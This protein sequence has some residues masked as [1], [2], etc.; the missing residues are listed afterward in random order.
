MINTEILQ[1]LQ[2][3]DI[4]ISDVPSFLKK[5]NELSNG[6]TVLFRGHCN[7]QYELIPSIGRQDNETKDFFYNK[8]DEK[9]MFLEFK[10][11]YSLFTDDKPSSDIDVLFLAQHF[12]VPTR[13]LDWTYNPLVALFFAC[14]GKEEDGGHVYTI[15]IPKDQSIIKDGYDFDKGFFDENKY[16]KEQYLIVPDY[17][18]RR[19]LNQKGLF[20]L[21]K[22]PFAKMD[23][24][25]TFIISNKNGV[26][27][28]LSNMG[29]TESMVFPTLDGLGKEIANKYKRL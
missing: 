19:F 13:L 15:T 29:I 5:L 24:S 10:R 7:K 28:E 2:A 1:S 16:E 23:I 20:L 8:E 17:T 22:N 21:F 26:L 25:P 11:N 3:Q 12:G 9:Q 6:Q 4:E 27:K 18:N 14:Q